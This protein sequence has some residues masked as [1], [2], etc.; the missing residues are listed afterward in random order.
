MKGKKRKVEKT[1]LTPH[2]RLHGGGKD[3]CTGQSKIGF[4]PYMWNP[5]I[6]ERGQGGVFS[7][8]DPPKKARK[9]R[10]RLDEVDALPCCQG[11]SLSEG[12]T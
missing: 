6:R 3:T 8:K 5:P 11:V 9:K 12:G 4:T 2:A 1:P 10:K 7:A